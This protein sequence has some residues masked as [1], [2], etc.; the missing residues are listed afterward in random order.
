MIYF[1]KK[2]KAERDQNIL[3][4]VL[5]ELKEKHDNERIAKISDLENQIKELKKS[6]RWGSAEI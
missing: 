4:D 5:L 6:Q 1:L 3:D 2:K